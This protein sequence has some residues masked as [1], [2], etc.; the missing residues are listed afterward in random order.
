MA[1]YLYAKKEKN[2]FLTK[3][4]STDP[5]KLV[6]KE[7]SRGRGEKD[8]PWEEEM[9]EISEVDCRWVGMGT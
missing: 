3:L 2:I 7:G 9:E 5:E 8:S 6:I 1:F 4:Q